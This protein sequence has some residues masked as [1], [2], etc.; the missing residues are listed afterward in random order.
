MARV[1]ICLFLTL[2]FAFG[3]YTSFMSS[4]YP[5]L[6][7]WMTYYKEYKELQ[8]ALDKGDASKDEMLDKLRTM[9]PEKAA[10]IESQFKAKYGNLKDSAE[11]AGTELQSKWDSIPN[12]DS[13]SQRIQEEVSDS[14]KSSDSS[15]RSK[16]QR[17]ESRRQDRDKR[18][19][20]TDSH[21]NNRAVNEKDQ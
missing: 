17:S 5:A 7:R 6:K 9:Y 10:E 15:T 2:A 21:D 8:G 12:N 13:R 4:D 3:S 1:I 19:S 14:Q 11:S 16:E 20:S 18:A